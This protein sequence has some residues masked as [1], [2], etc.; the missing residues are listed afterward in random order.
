MKLEINNKVGKIHKTVDIKQQA[1]KQP[2]DKI[3]NHKGYSKI[4]RGRW[5]Q[6]HNILKLIVPK[7]SG[8]KGDMYSYKFLH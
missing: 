5:K 3:R 2:V 1:F 7:K 8:V 4:I 6:K